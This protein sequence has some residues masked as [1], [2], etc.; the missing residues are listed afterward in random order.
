MGGC[1][2][3]DKYMVFL[4]GKLPGKRASDVL[5]EGLIERTWDV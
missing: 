2:V 1:F 5:L 4:G 3:E